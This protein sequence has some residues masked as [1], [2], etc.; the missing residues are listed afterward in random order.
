MDAIF[1]RGHART[2]N[3][4]KNDVIKFFDEKFNKPHWYVGIWDTTTV[5]PL[6]LKEDFKDSNLIYVNSNI[7]ENSLEDRFGRTLFSVET[8]LKLY[9]NS[10]LKISYL[11]F[12]LNIE[13]KE[14]ELSNN[15]IYDNVH[16]IRPDILYEEK[17]MYGECTLKMQPMEVTGLDYNIL[18]DD[19]NFT[20]FS[21]FYMKAGSV[22]TNIFCSRFF[23][24][25][26]NYIKTNLHEN[27]P[28]YK[29]AAHYHRVQYK[30]EKNNLLAA[31]PIRPDYNDYKSRESEIVEEGY[32]SGRYMNRWSDLSKEK[33]ISKMVEYIDNNNIDRNDYYQW[34][35][36]KN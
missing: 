23:D 8:F 10:Y 28:H 35:L 12:F 26:F 15:L 20:Q 6:S 22:A 7:N 9:Q 34:L 2:W 1:L 32:Y 36:I 11:D 18:P 24:V 16:F 27:N 29:L 3:L 5:T 13:K 31:Y 30:N 25:D 14:Y 33:N 21:D 17:P 19:G 4:I